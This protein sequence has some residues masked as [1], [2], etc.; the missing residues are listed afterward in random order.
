MKSSHRSKKK[1]NHI[2]FLSGHQFYVLGFNCWSSCRSSWSHPS[3]LSMARYYPS[4]PLK[5]QIAA[6][7]LHCPLRISSPTQ[8]I[9]CYWWRALGQSSAGPCKPANS[10]SSCYR[11]QLEWHCPRRTGSDHRPISGKWHG[12]GKHMTGLVWSPVDRPL[13]GRRAFV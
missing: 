12:V 2:K 5:L 3:I 9:P 6:R 1:T 7:R 13:T 8:L 10:W 11:T 4:W